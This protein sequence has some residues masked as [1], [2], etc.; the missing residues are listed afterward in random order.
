[1]ITIARIKSI[2]RTCI[3]KSEAAS[4][5]PWKMEDGGCTP[6]PDYK[7]GGKTFAFINDGDFATSRAGMKVEDAAF[8]SCARTLTPHVCRGY[9]EMIEWLEVNA[10]VMSEDGQRASNW[11][12]SIR[13]EWDKFEHLL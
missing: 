13:Q 4:P 9:L 1:M 11:L 2:L 5:E 3:A 7:P 6:L 8:I 10:L 12:E